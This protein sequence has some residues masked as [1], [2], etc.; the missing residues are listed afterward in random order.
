MSRGGV[1]SLSWLI[2]QIGFEFSLALNDN[3]RHGEELMTETQQIAPSAGEC[4]L[5][6][7]IPIKHNT[8]SQYCFHFGTA[9]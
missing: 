8:L 7:F 2:L 5:T 4:H 6:H 3:P 1:F 9:S